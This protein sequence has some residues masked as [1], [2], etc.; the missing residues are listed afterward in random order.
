LEIG[1]IACEDDGVEEVV[2]ASIASIS[3][4]DEVGG[5]FHHHHHHH[6]SEE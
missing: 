3:D 4:K 6:Q 2:S 1:G 5:S